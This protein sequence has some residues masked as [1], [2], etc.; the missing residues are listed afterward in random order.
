MREALFLPRAVL[1]LR[2]QWRHICGLGCSG[3]CGREYATEKMASLHNFRLPTRQEMQRYLKD[4]EIVTAECLFLVLTLSNVFV[5]YRLFLDVVPFPIFVTWWQLAQGLFMAWCLGETGTEFSKFAYFPRVGLDKGLLR[6]IL[7]PAL[8]HSMMLVLANIVVYRTPCV[9]TLPVI[10][11]FAVVLHHVTRF[12]GC[13][14]EYM[15]MRWQ[16]IGMLFVAFVLGCTDQRTLGA[17]VLPWA[18]LYAVFSAAFRAAYLQKVMHEVDGRGN[19]LHNHQHLIGVAVLPILFL[20]SGEWRIFQ[21]IP[22][23]FGLLQTWQVWGCLVT[24]GALPFVKNI[25]S[26]RLIRRTGQ[27][28]WRLLEIVSIA[29]VFLIGLSFG[30][31]GWQGFICILLV[32][33]GRAFC[34]YDVITN[35]AEAENAREARTGGNRPHLDTSAELEGGG[36]PSQ[37]PFL[38]AIDEDESEN[39]A[40]LR[41]EDVTTH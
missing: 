28:P 33:A 27:G 2:L 24:V 6:R 23:N 40:D 5:M 16:A 26:N 13:G 39:Y 19:L 10:V 32:V 31:P 15:P 20:L 36:Q 35:A 17:Q 30:V 7:V 22:L 18:I 9:A 21:T 34:A 41:G 29:L 14:E 38:H 25:V 4:P 3:L 8:V 11:S 1:L 37:K 12:I